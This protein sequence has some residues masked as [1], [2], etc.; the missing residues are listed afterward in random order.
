MLSAYDKRKGNSPASRDFLGSKR[1]PTWLAVPQCDG[2]SEGG[3][4]APGR[5][6]AGALEVLTWRGEMGLFIEGEN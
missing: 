6:E 2:C 3:V 5:T 1:R 4:P